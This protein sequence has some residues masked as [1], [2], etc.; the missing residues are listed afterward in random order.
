MSKAQSKPNSVTSLLDNKNARAVINFH[1]HAK[2]PFKLTC[3][4]YTTRIESELMNEKFVHSMQSNRV[5]AAF[6]KVKS[7]IKKKEPPNINKSQLNYFQHDFN[8]NMEIE[9]VINIDLKSAYAT[10]L[11]NKGY[12]SESTYAYLHTI[13]KKD[14]L[15]SVG[16]LASRKIIFE[17][18]KEG[19][20]FDVQENVSEYENYF[21]YA[22]KETYAIMSEL[23]AII[24]SGY[25][26][27]WVDGIYFTGDVDTL[28]DCA[29]HLDACGFNF[30]AEILDEFKLSYTDA[31]VRLSF[32]KDG[33]PKQFALPPKMV[34]FNKIITDAIILYNQNSQQNEK[35]NIEVFQK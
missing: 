8:K 1:K 15:A 22:V 5:F 14:R 29:E 19:E 26:F 3:S 23:R 16:M 25:L 7:D 35:S 11:L 20:I 4:N 2:I 30:T 10:I 13:P 17:F 9:S 21:Y 18:N 24:G 6:S 32:L 27:T 34:E 28:I 31:G 12:I 33:K